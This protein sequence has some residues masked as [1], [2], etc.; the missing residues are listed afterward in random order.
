MKLINTAIAA[1]A[2]MTGLGVGLALGAGIAMAA[3]ASMVLQK[4]R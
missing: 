3:Q 4:V 2:T 1:H